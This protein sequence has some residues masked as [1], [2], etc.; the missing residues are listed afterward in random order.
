MQLFY[1]ENIINKQAILNMDE[2][3]H[4]IRVLR[5]KKGDQVKLTDG[6]GYFYTGVI[7]QDNPKQTIINLEG[8]AEKAYKHPYHLHVAIAPTKNMDRME[9]FVEKA[10]E[11]GVDEITPILCRHSERKKL[12]EDRLQKII[13]SAMKQSMKADLPRLN[14]LTPLADLLNS[15]LKDVQ[16]LIAHLEEGRKQ[17][18]IKLRPQYNKYLVLIGPEGD[19]DPSEIS[20]AIQNAFVPVSLGNYR[21][22]TE[23]AGVAACQIIADIERIKEMG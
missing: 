4:C 10:V 6:K 11:I 2:S 3:S 13:L 23:T 5:R 19:F 22:R 9:W 17:K 7:T 12:R 1:S 8:K 18:L 20:P 14:R 15:G 21:L 16:K